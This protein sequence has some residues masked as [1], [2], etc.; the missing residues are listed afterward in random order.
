MDRQVRLIP[1]KVLKVHAT[2][3]V[4]KGVEMIKAP[5]VW[6]ASRQ[7][8]G[9]VVAI[10]D[11]GCQTNHPSLKG[12]IIGG[13]N[14]TEDYNKNPQKF[15]DNNG[16]GTHVAGIVAA[17]G[18]I[19]GVAPRAS[20]IILKVLDG[21]GTGEFGPIIEGIY[22]SVNWRGKNGETVR[23]ISMSL[24]TKKDDS[25]LHRAIKYAVENDVLVICAAGNEGDGRGHTSEKLYPGSYSEVMQIGAVDLNGKIADF[26]NSNDEIDMVAPGVDIL[27]TWPGSEYAVLSG[28]SMATPHVAGAAALIINQTEK[29]FNRRLS[30]ED[31]YAQV[32]KRTV[33]LGYPP[34]VEGNGLIM[35]TEGYADK[36]KRRRI[37]KT[38][39]R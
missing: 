25:S 23:I 19:M 22:D 11:T 10:L 26:S 3:N 37:R 4:E 18:K 33:T 1:Y 38:R 16:H 7:G 21:D 15:N 34:T 5:E 30:G 8:K 24:G 31:I 36:A 29:D 20:L 6:E 32:I 9:V 35:L 28:T 2:G 17:N 12:R 27:S 39:K 14:Y 13:R